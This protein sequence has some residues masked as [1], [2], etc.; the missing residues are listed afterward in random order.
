MPSYEAF[1]GIVTT[2]VQQTAKF[3]KTGLETKSAP[4][5]FPSC[6]VSTLLMLGSL[7]QVARKDSFAEL[8]RDLDAVE[9]GLVLSCPVQVLLP[10]LLTHR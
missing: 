1:L 9:A 8:S 4:P 6:A 2:M 5:L 10:S 3:V 7:I